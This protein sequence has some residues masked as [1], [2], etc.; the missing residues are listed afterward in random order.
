M[1]ERST[2]LLQKPFTAEEILEVIRE[3]RV[4]VQGQLVSFFPPKYKQ[5]YESKKL[6]E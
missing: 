3:M 6:E 4:S 1:L 2:V 5:E